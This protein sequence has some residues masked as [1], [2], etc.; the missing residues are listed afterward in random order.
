LHAS[1]TGTAARWDVGDGSEKRVPPEV[2]G[3]PP[4]DFIEQIRLDAAVQRCGRQHRVLKLAPVRAPHGDLGQEPLPH[5]FQRQRIGRADAGPGERIGGQAEEDLAG[6]G[7]VTRV[8]RLPLAEQVRHCGI[9]GA[10]D[11]HS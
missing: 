7:V 11:Q 3:L 8:Q 6:K 1:R 5:R 9:P 2:V 10:K 4:A